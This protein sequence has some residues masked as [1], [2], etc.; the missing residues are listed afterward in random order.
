MSSANEETQKFGVG[1]LQD[2]KTV[3]NII[4]PERR[5]EE[6]DDVILW[7]NMSDGVPAMYDSPY[8]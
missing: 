8:F 7:L 3:L 5:T 4:N 2:Y 6:Q 1:C